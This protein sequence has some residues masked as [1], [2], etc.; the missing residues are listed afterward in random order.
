MGER[1]VILVMQG[2]IH[3]SE[4]SWSRVAN[5][6]SIVQPGSEVQC[7]LINIDVQQGRIQL[8]LKVRYHQEPRLL[9]SSVLKALP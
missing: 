8:S 6:E 9:I 7:K 5:I 2:L 1:S 4:L 3:I